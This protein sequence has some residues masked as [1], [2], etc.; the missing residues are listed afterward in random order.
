[1]PQTIMCTSF[2]VKRSKVKVTRP[3]TAETES[4]SYLQNAKVFKIFNKKKFK[5]FKIATSMEHAIKCHGQL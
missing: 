3:I 5:N 2:K 1:M 4:V